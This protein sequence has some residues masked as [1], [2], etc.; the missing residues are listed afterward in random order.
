MAASALLSI[1]AADRPSVHHPLLRARGLV[2]AIRTGGNQRRF[3]A[4]DIR[5][6]PSP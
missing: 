4:I 3:P 1:G 2:G 6:P 5:R